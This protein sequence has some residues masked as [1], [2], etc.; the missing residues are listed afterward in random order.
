MKT[1][2]ILGGVGPQ[3]TSKVY[4]SVIDLVRKNKNDKYPPILIYNLPFP[5]IIEDEAIIQGIN[6]E[7]MLPYLI[8]GAKILE[9]AGADFGILPCNTLHKYINEIRES[10]RFPFLSILEETV[11]AL[12]LKK[13]KTVGI[14]ATETTI[15]SKIYENV[16]RENGIDIVYP[17][18]TEQQIINNSIVELLNGIKNKSHSQ[19][20]EIICK[21]LKKKGAENILLAC[22]DLQLVLA[23]VNSSV[24]IIDT[25][26]I[27]IQASVR[28]LLKK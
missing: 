23:D 16:L 4:L 21:S 22:T 15:Q 18:Q 6:S 7:K 24:S 17:S 26:G 20:I 5:F 8:D 1:L 19:N 14:L 3:T 9:K 11:L 25:T 13:I 2:G 12:K 28:E 10:V 27:L